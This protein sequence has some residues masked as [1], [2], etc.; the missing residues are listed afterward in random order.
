MHVLDILKYLILSNAETNPAIKK[1]IRFAIAISVAMT[2]AT[3]IG[4]AGYDREVD[5]SADD[6][7]VRPDHLMCQNKRKRKKKTK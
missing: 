2:I 3:V 7:V 4:V 5:S 6:V 1:K